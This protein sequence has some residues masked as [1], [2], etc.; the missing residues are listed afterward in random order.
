MAERSPWPAALAAV[1]EA[2]LRGAWCG[3]ASL[4]GGG[5]WLIE[6][7]GLTPADAAAELTAFAAEQGVERRTDI[8]KLQ[9]F[10]THRCM[11]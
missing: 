11:V 10:V 3:R 2:E 8:A 5:L 9:R 4:A 6:R 1:R 7:Y